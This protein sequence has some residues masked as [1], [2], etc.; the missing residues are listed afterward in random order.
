VRGERDKKE[1]E[2]KRRKRQKGERDKKEKE[3]KRR[4][5]Q[6][7]ERDKEEKRIQR[8]RI[9]RTSVARTLGLAKKSTL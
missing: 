3:T 2:T 5:R 4:K 7:G 8:V 9:N 1:K 6:K